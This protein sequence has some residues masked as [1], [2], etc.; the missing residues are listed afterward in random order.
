MITLYYCPHQT[1]KGKGSIGAVE[2]NNI[3][4]YLPTGATLEDIVR[5]KEIQ[6][7]IDPTEE[8][9]SLLKKVEANLKK[10]LHIEEEYWK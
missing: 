10:Y 6:L 3:W 2:Q 8:N 1:E 4:K 7:E 9:M 5:A